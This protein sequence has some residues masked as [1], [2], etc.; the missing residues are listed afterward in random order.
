MTNYKSFFSVNKSSLFYNLGLSAFASLFNSIMKFATIFFISRFF[1][2]EEFGLWAAVTSIGTIIGIGGDFGI[3]N[4][5]RVKLSELFVS[6]NDKDNEA[7][8]YFFTSFFLLFIFS[9][10]LL[11]ILLFLYHILPVENLFN[12]DNFYLK[13]EG[14]ELLFFTQGLVLL[15]VPFSI[16]GAA[17]FSYNESKISS[18]LSLLQSLL[19]IVYL[20]VGIYMSFSILLISVGSFLLNFLVNLISSIYFIHRR[21]W[22]K[23]I[24][25]FKFH[26]FSK[27][28][29]FLLKNGFNYFT[30]NFSKGYLENIGTVIASS[31]FSLNVAADYNLV[32][33]VYTAST[34]L[35]LSIFNP[36]WGAFSE[37]AFKNNWK[38]C[39]NV[40]RK[41]IRFTF[42]LITMLVIFFY[43]FGNIILSLL[44]GTNHNIDPFLFILIGISTLF[45][46]L[47]TSATS[48]LSAINRIKLIIF[49]MILFS[50]ILTYTL[51]SQLVFIFKNLNSLVYF[52]IF[53]WFLSFLAGHL[54]SLIYM[55]KK[56]NFTN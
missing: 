38:W 18:Y 44:T 32:Q 12:T 46:M 6:S 11:F 22:L 56:L 10:C 17:F 4:S 42:I 50:F 30:L 27:Q 31:H 3:G 25:L 33:K 54:Q 21:N 14:K 37:N 16:G 43:F 29:V 28:S 45:Y 53:I 39:I 34:S 23:Y 55:K 19:S 51:N 15:A 52:L 20:F 8:N 36:L 48:F 47:Y 9:I 1:T 35:Y 24:S 5:L 13:N 40:Y 41:T 7:S 49:M 26:F 2:K